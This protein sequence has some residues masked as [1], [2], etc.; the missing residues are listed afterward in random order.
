MTQRLANSIF[1][2]ALIGTCC[3]LFNMAL[4]FRDND[5]LGASELSSRFFPL[6]MLGFIIVCAAV[7]IVQ[8][9]VTGEAG[10][11]TEYVYSHWT[12]PVRALLVLC[13]TFASYRIWQ[14]FGFVPMSLF[15]GPALCAAMAA[16]SI[17]S[18]AFLLAFGPAVHFV[19]HN[20]LGIQLG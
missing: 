20:V 3:V 15:I 9:A 16:R 18:Y 19:F 1:C 5:L 14:D 7:V 10:D 8:Y 11:E 13:L 4:D 12:E 17:L 2:V 6:L